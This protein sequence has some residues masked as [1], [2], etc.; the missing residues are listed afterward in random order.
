[1]AN[2]VTRLKHDIKHLNRV[3]AERK[4]DHR[5]LRRDLKD[6]KADR[7]QVERHRD[8][9]DSNR[10]DLKGDRKSLGNLRDT[11]RERMD[12]FDERRAALQAQLDA[13]I[14]PLTGQPDLGL[15]MQ[16]SA[17]EQRAAEV[18]GELTGKIDAKRGEVERGVGAAER[19]RD[20]IHD[21]RKDI[22]GDRREVKHDRREL[23]HDRREV[24]SA[25]HRAL[26]HLRPAEYEMGLKATNR[27]RRE[28]GL[29]P[30]D[31]VIRPGVPN[32]VGGKVGDWIAEAQT[33]LKRHGVPMSKM[34]AKDIAIIIRHESGGNPNAVNNWDSNAAAGTPSKGLMQTIGPTFNAYNLKG[35][36]HILNPV[37]NIIAATRYAIARYGSISNVPGVRAVKSG[38]AYVGY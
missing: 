8:A 23:K 38:G 13:S 31:H 19:I 21:D 11:F 35:H 18:S 32:V 37:D 7:R 12:G 33:I 9:F 27:A 10:K 17:L 28:L 22:H 20:A 14:D 29:K 15:Q 24:K 3:Q 2:A 4:K 36:G 1:M 6:L 5:E 25:R 16:L 26:E 34:S 30:V